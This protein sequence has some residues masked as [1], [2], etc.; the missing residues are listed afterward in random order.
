M[1]KRYPTLLLQDML[2]A[3]KGIA[4]SVERLNF[5]VLNFEGFCVSR[6]NMNS[7]CFAIHVLGEAANSMP[8]TLRESAPYVPWRHIRAYRNR[9]VH[10]YFDIDYDFLWQ[11]A[12]IHVPAL[13]TPLITFQKQ[14]IIQEQL[15]K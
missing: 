8:E 6:L 9:I 15:E 12:T 7:C 14:I 11:I 5:E 13:K 4:Q 1:S 3:I 10:E 2:Q